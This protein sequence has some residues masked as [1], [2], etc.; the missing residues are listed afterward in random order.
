MRTDESSAMCDN[1]LTAAA[2]CRTLGSRTSAT[3]HVRRERQSLPFMHTDCA[4]S[5]FSNASR[6]DGKQE[7]HYEYATLL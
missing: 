7:N 4:D 1:E 2:A 5:H 6:S 3:F